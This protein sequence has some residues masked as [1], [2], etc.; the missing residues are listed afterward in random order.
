MRSN[1][2]QRVDA[3]H[4]WVNIVAR[5]AQLLQQ[6]STTYQQHTAAAAPPQDTSLIARQ[7]FNELRSDTNFLW[8]AQLLSA[9]ERTGYV[10]LGSAY[11]LLK[12]AAPQLSNSVLQAVIASLTSCTDYAIRTRKATTVRHCTPSSSSSLHVSHN[13]QT[14]TGNASLFGGECIK[15][16]HLGL[17]LLSWIASRCCSLVD[18]VAA[19]GDVWKEMSGAYD[20][21]GCSSSPTTTHHPAH[22][23]HLQ[24]STTQ[25]PMDIMLTTNDNPYNVFHTVEDSVMEDDHGSYLDRWVVDRWLH[26]WTNDYINGGGSPTH[27][28]AAPNASATFTTNA[29]TPP[30]TQTSSPQRSAR[31]SLCHGE[32]QH[33]ISPTMDANMSRFGNYDG[34]TI[35][36]SSSPLG[37]MRGA[38]S[39]GAV[40]VD[41]SPTPPPY[42]HTST[43]ASHNHHNEGWGCGASTAC[44]EASNSEAELDVHRLQRIR[45]LLAA[46]L[47]HCPAPLLDHMVDECIEELNGAEQQQQS[48]SR[49]APQATWSM[50]ERMHALIHFV[51]HRW[52]VGVGAAYSGSYVSSCAVMHFDATKWLVGAATTDSD[53]ASNPSFIRST[54]IM[55]PS[56]KESPALRPAAAPSPPLATGGVIV[57]DMAHQDEH[58]I[59][60]YQRRNSDDVSTT[61]RHHVGGGD[62]DPAK[63]YEVMSLDETSELN[64]TKLSTTTLPHQTTTHTTLTT[65]TSIKRRHE[66]KHK[67]TATTMELEN[68]AERSEAVSGGGCCTMM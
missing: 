8:V 31:A 34:S 66:S 57:A 2:T 4:R 21:T 41:R 68:M 23:H 51:A 46:M 18:V 58:E 48:S 10:P 63:R 15:V 25:Q 62:R 55:T 9:D 29:A 16:Q 43:L 65:T 42:Q 5:D 44:C 52:D 26:E 47:P 13:H 24:Q 56:L 35:L 40:D 19:Y 7:V 37:I 12:F 3:F 28:A 14:S 50:G 27:S 54:T 11:R 36:S 38:H 67:P 45:Q 33:V 60:S 53:R 49:D 32:G 1:V 6:S 17:V 61:A 59:L 22:H 20:P 30:P 64:T 39:P